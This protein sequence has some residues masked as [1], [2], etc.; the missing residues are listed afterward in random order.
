[1][2]PQTFPRQTL[3]QKEELTPSQQQDLTELVDQFP[4][5][6]SAE[7]GLTHLVQ[8]DIKIPPG[9]VVRQRPYQVPAARSQVIEEKVSKMLWDGII[10]ESASPWSSPIMVVSKPDRSL[11]VCN[12][13]YKLNQLCFIL[14]IAVHI[15]FHI[16]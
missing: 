13:F 15:I 16:T 10:K 11:K 3:I 6:F 5:L 7:S 4:D 12:D 2:S 9:V 1:M 8:H 14:P